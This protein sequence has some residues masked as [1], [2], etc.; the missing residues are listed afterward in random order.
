MSMG[1]TIVFSSILALAVLG[2]AG[3]LIYRG[4]NARTAS[5]GDVETLR[6]KT[7]LLALVAGD[8]VVLGVAV[9]AAYKTDG[10]TQAA[11]LSAAFSAVTAITASFFS[12][13]AA[14][15]TAAKAIEK[16]EEGGHSREP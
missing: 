6:S 16:L 14:S 15:N 1:E 8:V 13:R 2:L 11:V 7:G 5:T 9:V 3:A 10:D 4:K 12:I